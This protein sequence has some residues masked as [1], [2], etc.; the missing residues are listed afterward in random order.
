MRKPLH[1]VLVILL[2]LLA[3][4]GALVTAA[5]AADAPEGWQ[6]EFEEVCS[7]TQDAM[8]FNARELKALVQRCD[9]LAPQIEKLDET[10]R[11]VYGPRLRQCRGVFT[12]VLESKSDQ[13]AAESNSKAGK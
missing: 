4:P 5:S 3:W 1:A 10:R 13:N 2:A 7:Q 9:A 8:Q 12:Y 11:K 6:K